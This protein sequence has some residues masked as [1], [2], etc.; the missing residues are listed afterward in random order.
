ML[1]DAWLS[2][3]PIDVTRST[4]ENIAFGD[5]SARSSAALPL[6]TA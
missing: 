6:T 3:P 1:S 4:T 5:E 2:Y